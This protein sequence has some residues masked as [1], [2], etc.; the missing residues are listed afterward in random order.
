V[1][2]GD[3]L[4][5]ARELLD[6]V[7]GFTHSSDEKLTRYFRNAVREAA[8][9]T[10]TLQDDSSDACRVTLVPGQARYP[11][12]PAILVVRAAY[13]PGRRQPLELVK[14]AVLDRVAP[15]WSHEAQQN[16][17]P[18][19]AVFDV[20]QKVIHLW[21]P[22]AEVGVMHLRVWRLPF[23]EE[24]FEVADLEA[25]SPIWLPDPESL[26][27][28]VAFEVYSEKDSELHDPARA[29]THLGYF[30][31]I[32]GPRPSNHDLQLWSTSRLVGMR[33]QSEY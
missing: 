30:E 3:L 9:R 2:L 29:S 4:Q 21:R 32:Y 23:E 24:E 5:A 16:A 33:M 28:W 20:G 15:G 22:P 26:K 25:E 6:D 11:L 18:R 7:G 13:V 8:L 14:A 27:H 31:G 19:Y 12:D 1:N 10:R 17:I